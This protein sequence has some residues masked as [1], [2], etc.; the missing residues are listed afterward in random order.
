MKKCFW[1]AAAAA[2]LL[3]ATPARA[4]PAKPEVSNEAT[5]AASAASAAMERAK[6]QAAGPMR[7]ILEASKSRRKVGDADGTAPASLPATP[8]AAPS[9]DGGSMRTVSSRSPSPSP[10]TPVPEPVTRSV[11][12]LA[13]TPV[14]LPVRVPP[15]EAATTPAAG[16]GAAPSGVVTEFTLTSETL[17][18]RT[19]AARVPGL[20]LSGAG[21]GSLAPPAAATLATVPKFATAPN[22][23]SLVKVQLVSQVDPAL[24]QRQLED[25]GRN[26][27]VSVDLTIRA[28]GTVRSVAMVPPTPRG[29]QRALLEALE[30]WRFSPLPE[31]RVHRVQLVFNPES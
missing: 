3:A 14:P 28:N 29:I 26:A 20:E 9:A 17:Q 23:G 4:Q 21:A 19:E 11:S 10:P 18:G 25:M 30:Q 5:A 2:L 6:R 7:V 8:P 24:T 13:P 27:L 22:T 31:E 1:A 16:A 12:A 15:V